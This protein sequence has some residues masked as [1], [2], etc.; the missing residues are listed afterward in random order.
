MF[1]H[2]KELQKKTGFTDQQISSAIGALHKLGKI[3]KPKTKNTTPLDGKWTMSLFMALRLKKEF[4]GTSTHRHHYCSHL[5][6]KDGVHYCPLL[7]VKIHNPEIHCETLDAIV[8]EGKEPVKFEL[9]YC[10]GHTKL[11]SNKETMEISCE[12]LLKVGI[13]RELSFRDASG[14]FYNPH[15]DVYNPFLIANRYISVD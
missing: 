15:R 11:S 8:W 4:I 1:S 10:E 12:R 6:M 13:T 5:R 9:P 2:T 3:Y 7:K 14:C